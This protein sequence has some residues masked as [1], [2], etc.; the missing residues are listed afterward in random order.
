MSEG[1]KKM[2]D[3]QEKPILPRTYLYERD[4]SGNLIPKRVA[5][6][7]K[8][9]GEVYY[10]KITPLTR[11]ERKKLAQIGLDSKGN[12]TEDADK[13]I[14]LKHCFEPKFTEDDIEKSPMG[15]IENIV[16]TILRESNLP[17]DKPKT[18]VDEANNKVETDFQNASTK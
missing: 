14:V 6:M 5:L 7:N 4:E 13:D 2:E 15:F 11:G 1:R 17:V 9:L 18:N 16:I 10:V 3:N 8:V 12:T